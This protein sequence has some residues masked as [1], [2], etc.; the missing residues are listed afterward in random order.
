MMGQQQMMDGVSL[1]GAA[2]IAVMAA[3]IALVMVH[4]GPIKK[5]VREIENI[6]LSEIWMF[7]YKHI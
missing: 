6:Q 3:A 4:I 1:V 7:F 2:S 5:L